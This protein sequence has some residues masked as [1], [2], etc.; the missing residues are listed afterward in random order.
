MVR[1]K[2]R[3]HVRN[4]K[5]VALFRRINRDTRG[6]MMEILDTLQY[7]AGCHVFLT[8]QDSRQFIIIFTFLRLPCT[9]DNSYYVCIFFVCQY[10][11]RMKTPVWNSNE[12]LHIIASLSYCFRNPKRGVG[13]VAREN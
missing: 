12:R 2:L 11:F 9:V 5:K 10:S 1:Q 7:F 8:I 4:T 3:N 6:E 13:G